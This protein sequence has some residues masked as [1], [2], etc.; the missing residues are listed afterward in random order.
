M[1]NILIFLPLLF[2]TISFAQGKFGGGDGSGYSSISLNNQSLPVELMYFDGELKSDNIHLYWA[3]ASEINNAGFSVEKSSD[4]IKFVSIGQLQGQGSSTTSKAYIFIDE[5]PCQGI[6]YYRLRQKD[7][8]G[9][10]SY[11]KVL[12]LDYLESDRSFTIAPN[13]FSDFLTI[14]IKEDQRN[15]SLQVF[16]LS[17]QLV[18]QS[19]DIPLHLDLSQLNAGVY[20]LSINGEVVK[21]VK[22]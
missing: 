7:F 11:S 13:P 17:G 5:H 18:F 10:T 3:T 6:N 1:K 22:K 4:A 15:Q 19:G 21:V 14:D 16:D 12:A 8:D 2:A 20:Y 9:K